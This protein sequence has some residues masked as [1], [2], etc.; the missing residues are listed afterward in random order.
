MTLFGEISAKNVWTKKSLELRVSWYLF[1][2]SGGH[3]FRALND[4]NTYTHCGDASPQQGLRSWSELIGWSLNMLEALKAWDWRKPYSSDYGVTLLKTLTNQVWFWVSKKVLLF[5]QKSSRNTEKVEL[6]E[7]DVTALTD[8][9]LRDELVKHG[10]VVGP[11][12]GESGVKVLRHHY[13]FSS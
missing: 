12:V 3:S 6:K 13:R 11:I 7:P 4:Q 5:P 2:Y 1:S 8:E 9:G 10:V